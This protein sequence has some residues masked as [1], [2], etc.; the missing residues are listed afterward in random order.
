VLIALYAAWN[1]K[2]RGPKGMPGLLLV[3]ITA[4][5]AAKVYRHASLFAIVWLVYVPSWLADTPLGKTIVERWTQRERV[6]GGSAVS[7]AVLLFASAV[8]AG[9]FHIRMPT[10][11]TA[12]EP[13]QLVYPAGPV[14]YLRDAHFE[15]NVMTNFNSG[16]YFTWR[17]YPAVKVGMDSRYDVAFKPGV[18]EEIIALYAMKPGWQATLARYPS[19]VLLTP[20]DGPMASL[21]PEPWRRVYVDDAYTLFARPGIELPFTDRRGQDIAA[22]FP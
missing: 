13:F 12:D 20:T 9:L 10:R 17:L 11:F 1:V 21:V 8:V 15:G 14:D 3:V 5:L 19:D 18:S 2:P 4:Y 16:S 22:S 7:L 6:L